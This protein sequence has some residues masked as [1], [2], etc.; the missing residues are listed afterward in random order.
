MA[1]IKYYDTSSSSWKYLPQGPPG[2][3]GPQGPAGSGSG[4]ML[5]S[6]YDAANISQQVVGT[7]ATQTL[8]N[9][10]LTSGTNTFPTLNQNTTG[11]AATLT[12]PRTIAGVSFDGSANI[13]IASTNLSN[14]ASIALTTNTLTLTN[15]RITK[16]VITATSSATPTPTGDT[17]DIWYLSTLTV[18]ATFAAP[19]G[20]PTDGQQLTIR[21]KSVA[22]QT[23]AWNAIYLSSGVAALPTTS[24]AGKT[25]TCGFSY[26]AAQVKWILLAV[27]NIG[28]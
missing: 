3:A 26:D 24:V 18:G 13:T 17:A 2:P 7:T 14:T 4:D 9:K 27:D 15:K 16:R 22:A 1:T 23:L 20:T 11:S 28:Y 8:A 5:K 10:D 12:T 25:I 19:T 21:I 6:T